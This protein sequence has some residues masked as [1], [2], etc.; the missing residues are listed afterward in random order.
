M[1]GACGMESASPI[2]AGSSSSSTSA[3]ASSG[4]GAGAG[5]AG[6]SSGG[7]A[8]AGEGS[9]GSGGAPDAGDAGDGG[10]RPG[11]ASGFRLGG[12]ARDAIHAMGRTRG[13]PGF[14]VGDGGTYGIAPTFLVGTTPPGVDLGNGPLSCPA[15]VADDAGYQNDRYSFIGSFDLTHGVPWTRCAVGALPQGVAADL[16]GHVACSGITDGATVIDFGQG[17]LTG[18]THDVFVT[19]Y[20]QSDGALLWAKRFT[21][22]GFNA[23][24][25][26]ALVG[27]VPSGGVLL[28]VLG[29]GT[30]DFDGGPVS[31]GS[32]S[33][34][35]LL[36]ARFSADGTLAWAKPL[37]RTS[38]LGGSVSGVAGVAVSDDEDLVVA[39]KSGGTLDFGDGLPV[40][41]NGMFLARY[42][43][44]GA[45]RFARGFGSTGAGIDYLQGVDV[46]SDGSAVITGTTG[47]DNGST[48]VDFGGGPLTK[49][50]GNDAFLAKFGP[51][52]A[53]RFAKLFGTPQH[54][55]GGSV[56]V[57][58]GTIFA[59][60]SFMTSLDVGCGALS[61][62][63][64][65]AAYV[66]RFTGDG[67]CVWS[68]P[69]QSGPIG[70]QPSKLLI[71]FDKW[72]GYP[73]WSNKLEAGNLALVGDFSGSWQI[74][75]SLLLTSAGNNDLMFGLM[76]PSSK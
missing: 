61:S 31:I 16:A 75:P 2:V 45:L 35:Q 3:G 1:A 15:P 25:Q 30:F 38:G 37:T 14:V 73:Y 20:A 23:Y 39:G 72:R 54:E 22:E 13:K 53:L 43:A 65:S 44:S 36:A 50:G 68:R 41:S 4:G 70:G 40:T 49:K 8:G 56:S 51:D 27:A 7:G 57:I 76:T 17:P 48:T 34:N 33:N 63:N 55:S 32:S 52:G 28:V 47:S 74:E 59:S 58:D 19:Q 71:A 21:V 64:G 5:S 46:D 26:T 11:V 42:D 10:L 69:L 12:V 9:G 62:V 29:R 67:E 66:A 24:S 6:T 60:G 18:S